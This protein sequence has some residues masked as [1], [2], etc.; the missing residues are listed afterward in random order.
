MICEYE[1]RFSGNPIWCKV[2][3]TTEEIRDCLK[4]GLLRNVQVD[5]VKLFT[6]AEE[7]S[8]VY[9]IKAHLSGEGNAWWICQ[10]NQ[11]EKE[12]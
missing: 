1:L 10:E 6:V 2:D 12:S 11:D 8:M 7:E 9:D 4:T 5:V 3:A